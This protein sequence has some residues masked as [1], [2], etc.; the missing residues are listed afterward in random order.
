MRRPDVR[1]ALAALVVCAALIANQSLA[2]ASGGPR[3]SGGGTVD[4]SLGAASQL[5][6]TASM[7]GGSFL[8]L[9]AG[10]SGGFPFGPWASVSQMEVKGDVTAGSL[11]ITG[12]WSRF[13]GTAR[14]HVVGKTSTGDVLIVTLTDMAYASTQTEGGVGAYHQLDI[15]GVG[16]F[17]GRLRSGRINFTH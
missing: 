9:M 12:T 3:V 6:L 15:P 13:S 10:Q 5:G 11:T 8:C 7:S 17:A 4:D 1:A 16:T 2:F 14:I